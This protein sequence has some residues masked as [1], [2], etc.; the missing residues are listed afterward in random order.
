MTKTTRAQRES[1]AR[2][3]ERWN[4]DYQTVRRSIVPMFFGDG[5]VIVPPISE[6]NSIWI[7]VETDGYAHT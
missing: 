5:A 6:V 1:I 2:I 7:A 4:A 3:A